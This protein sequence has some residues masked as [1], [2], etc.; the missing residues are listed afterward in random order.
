MK[1]K[2]ILNLVSKILFNVMALIFGLTLIAGSLLTNDDVSNLLTSFVFKD[3][4]ADVVVSTGKEP[5]RYKTWYSSVE[6]TLNGNGQIARI[7]QAEGTVLLKNEENALPLAAGTKV[8]LYG[9]TAYD[10]MYCLDGAGNNKT[11]CRKFTADS[12][13]TTSLKKPVSI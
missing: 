13:S 7:A 11:A 10:P 3:K 1:I 4:P 6:D 12:S 5:V 2:K 9:V 8:S